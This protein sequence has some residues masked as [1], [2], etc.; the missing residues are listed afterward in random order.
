MI[1]S[2]DCDNKFTIRNGKDLSVIKT[3]E[4]DFGSMRCGLCYTDQNVLILGID[5]NLIEFDYE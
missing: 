5:E 1:L 3:I 2:D 4:H